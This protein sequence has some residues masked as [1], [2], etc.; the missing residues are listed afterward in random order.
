MPGRASLAGNFV[1]LYKS[2]IVAGVLLGGVHVAAL[3][4]A[5]PSRWKARSAM[6]RPTSWRS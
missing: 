6:P 2:L 1:N 4:N 5:P 3:A